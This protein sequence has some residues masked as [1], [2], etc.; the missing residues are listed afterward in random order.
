M[1]LV[2][3]DDERVGEFAS[4]GLGLLIV[5]PFVSIGVVNQKGNLCGSVI[6][7]HYNGPNVEIT[8]F[9]PGAMKR[10]IIRAC[11]SYP[12]HQLGVI[13]VSAR[14]RRSNKAMCRM[15]PRLGFKFEG[16]M[17]NYFGPY[18]NDDAILYCLMRKDAAK[19]IGN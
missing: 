8:I 3:G 6:Y 12:F 17:K 11:L 15:L 14:T 13:R 16:V 7:N 1:Q 9:G 19:W 10:G 2:F 18:R 5:P 4:R